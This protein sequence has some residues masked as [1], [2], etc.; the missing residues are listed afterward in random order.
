MLQNQK[1]LNLI[2]QI[3]TCQNLLEFEH[4]SLPF[5]LIQAIFE[6]CQLT[7]TPEVLKQLSETEPETLES[8]AIALS[9]TLGTQLELLNSWQPLL[10]SF[11]LSVSLKQRISDRNQSLKTLINEKSE[12]LKSSSLILSQEQQICQETQELKT[13]KSK[14]QQLT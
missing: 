2:E 7:F 12:L 9:K 14:I 13:L 10:D 8:W 11:P 3:K 6:D 5:E 4:I 1:N